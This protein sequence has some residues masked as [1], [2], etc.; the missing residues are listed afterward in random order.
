[1]KVSA[2]TIRWQCSGCDHLCALLL[3]ELVVPA[4]LVHLTKCGP[5]QKWRKIV[6]E[7]TDGKA[8]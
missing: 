5:S 3:D 6:Q 7:V 1:M 8:V 4:N 2:K